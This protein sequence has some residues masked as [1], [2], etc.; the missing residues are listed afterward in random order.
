MT[1]SRVTAGVRKNDD[2]KVAEALAREIGATLE[3]VPP[4]PRGH[5]RARFVLADGRVGEVGL[6]CTPARVDRKAVAASMR[7][8][9]RAQGVCP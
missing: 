5:P 7:K 6:S 8:K 2:F 9:L 3:V 4:T 1:R